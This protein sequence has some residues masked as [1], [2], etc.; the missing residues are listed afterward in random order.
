MASSGGK[1]RVEIPGL[2]DLRSDLK[3]L[4]KDVKRAAEKEFEEVAEIVA[5]AAARR[6]PSRT[7]N[8]INTIRAKGTIGGG[9]IVAGGPDAPYYQWLDFGGRDPQTGNSIE[10]GPWRGSGA[11]PT[12]GRFIYPAIKEN[13][14][15]ILRA[16]EQAVD[17]AARKA[18]FK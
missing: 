2:A 3:G 9:S 5:S 8:A 7:G 6:V 10:E 17:R 15:D 12:G 13:A 16:A 11:G 14:R 18:G 4:P 1:T